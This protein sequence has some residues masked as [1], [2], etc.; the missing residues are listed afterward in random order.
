MQNFSFETKE[1]K[2]SIDEVKNYCDKAWAKIS[3][4]WPLQNVIAS[5]PLAGLENQ[6]FENALKK[7]SH[8][9]CQ[10]KFPKKLE[11]INRISIKWFQVFFDDGQATIKMPDREKGFYQSWKNLALFDR[12]ISKKNPENIDFLKNLPSSSKQAIAQISKKLIRP[13][14]SEKFFTLLLTTLSG[15]SSYVKYLGEWSYQKNPQ[16]MIDYLAVRL[17]ITSM[18]WPKANFELI[19]WSEEIEKSEFSKKKI[20]EIITNEKEHIEELLSDISLNY[21]SE[22]NLEKNPDAQLVFCIDVRSEPFRKSLELVG[23]YETFGFAG[24]FGIPAKIIND[25]SGESYAS[26]PVLLSPKH[27]VVETSSCLSKKKKRQIAG[28][29]TILESKKIYQSLKYNFTTPLALAEGIGLL[30]GIWMLFRSFLPKGRKCIQQATNGALEQN[31]AFDPKIESISQ[32]DQYSYAL[33]ALKTIG[34][35]KDFA[36]IVVFCGHGSQTEN[37]SF[38]TALDCGACGGRHGDSNAKILAKI[39]SQKEVRKLLEKD[40]IIIPA[41]TIFLAAKHNTTSDEVEIFLPRESSLDEKK[42]EK[43]NQLKHDLASAKKINNLARAKNMGFGGKEEKIDQFIFNRSHSWSETQPEW[44]LAKNASFIVGPRFL[45]KKLDLKGRSFLHSYDSEIDEDCKILH[46]I[47]NAPMIVAQWINSQYLFSTLNNVAF[48]SGSKITQNIVGKIA[49]M[50]GNSS[51][52]MNGLPLQSVYLNDENKYHKPAR[53][54]S[55]ICAPKSK[56]D[57]VISISPKLQQLLVNNWIFLYCLEPKTGLLYQL[58]NDL[59]WSE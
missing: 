7:A 4:T 28:H 19:K 46:L 25:L 53:L 6:N 36:E 51:D 41:E 35:V 39:L 20:Q 22:E 43:I 29:A 3:P 38:A 30:S 59:T 2:S 5:N 21:D 17:I 27:D 32:E 12:E 45:T 56:I 26:C 42:R 23:K 31:H 44:G 34:L 18:I 58:K 47:L 57:Y 49:V 1:T 50:Q 33:G 13:E 54:A 16:I 55:L 37:N 9:F 40:K 15:W 8:L 10:K 48:G 11:E 14:T 24:F 52:L